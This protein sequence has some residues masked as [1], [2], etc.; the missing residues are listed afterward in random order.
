MISDTLKRGKFA[1]QCRSI[2]I[3]NCVSNLIVFFT[4]IADSD[5]IYLRFPDLTDVDF[6]TSASELKKHYV[7]K[8]V[9]HVSLF[10]PSKA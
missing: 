7:L 1:A 6:I 2:M 10:V 3:N 5:K 8:N 4:L 9:S